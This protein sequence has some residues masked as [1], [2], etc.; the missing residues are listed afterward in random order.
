[1]ALFTI[2]ITTSND[3]DVLE[4]I[5]QRLIA[6]KMAACCQLTEPVKSVYRWEGA[7][8]SAVEFELKIKT[9]T[10]RFGVVADL[11]QT[12]H[13]YDV[14]EICAVAI[15]EVSQSYGDWMKA[16]IE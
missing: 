6:N 14:P 16:Q 15:D 8:E 11:I 5:A 13:N 7:V 4:R 1:M 10:D 3:K 12:L 2:V 9:R